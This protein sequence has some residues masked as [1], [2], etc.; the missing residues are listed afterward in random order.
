MT[1]LVTNFTYKRRKKKAMTIM[2]RFINNHL[3]SISQWIR[4]KVADENLHL[5]VGQ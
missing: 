4:P 5:A 1:V 3:A 2:K